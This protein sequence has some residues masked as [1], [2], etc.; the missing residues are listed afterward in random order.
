MPSIEA[1]ARLDD[2]EAARLDSVLNGT[3]DEKVLAAIRG[4][5]KGNRDE[6]RRIVAA[7][8]LDATAGRTLRDGLA[9]RAGIL[10]SLPGPAATEMI[11]ETHQAIELLEELLGQLSGPHAA[12]ES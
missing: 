11:G 6:L 2:G 8:T 7:R 5:L 12:A 1:V 10:N 9:A 3:R 4:Q